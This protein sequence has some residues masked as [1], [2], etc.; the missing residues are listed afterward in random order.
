MNKGMKTSETA[1][2]EAA[3]ES[4]VMTSRGE[5]KSKVEIEIIGKAI[6]DFRK[7]IGLHLEKELWTV[8]QILMYCF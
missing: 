6:K 1:I 5:E 8:P 3:V 7:N 4:M 2:W